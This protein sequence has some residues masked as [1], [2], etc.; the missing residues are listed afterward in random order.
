[1]NSALEPQ[2]D[3]QAAWQRASP[4]AARDWSAVAYFF[5]RDL[6]KRLNVPV[7]I[8][9]TTWSGT[10]AEAWTDAASLA[11]DPD[12]EPILR[13]WTDAPESE[14]ELARRPA[15]YSLEF[16]DFELFADDPARGRV[17]SDFDDGALK[18]STGGSWTAVRNPSSEFGFVAQGRGGSAHALRYSGALVASTYAALN[19]TYAADNSPVD[20]SRYAGVRF[21]VRGR[22][23]F[24]IHSLQPSITDWD[25]YT[26]RGFAATPEWQRVTVRFD[27]LRQA[28][29]G[30]RHEFTP[31]SLTGFSVEIL[32]QKDGGP[33]LP[34]SSLFNA[35]V[36][37]LT[38]YSIRGAIWYQGESNAGRSYQYRKLL[39]ALIR[40]WRSAWGE[41]DFPFLV[42]QLAAYG[43]GPN[44]A[45]Q[46]GWAELREAQLMTL[47]NT[48][49]TGLAVTIDVGEPGNVHPAR[50]AEVGERLALWALGTTYGRRLVYSGPL[51]ESSKVEGGRVRIRFN[52]AGG[53]LATSDGGPLKGF[54]VAGADRVFHAAQA[55]VEGDAVVVSSPEVAR[56]L[57][58][59]YA[60]ADSPVCNLVNREGLPAS[61][62][63]TDDWP[64][65]TA[66]SK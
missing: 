37:P 43:A 63:R 16:D 65:V 8:I 51:Y 52:H 6:Q 22:G 53:G 2:T 26:T 24:K 39:P 40:G 28:G 18:T 57:A 47:R 19:A 14:K 44:A 56:P 13:R 50:K 64:G 12:F 36:A 3:F 31:Q 45:A 66:N 27:E 33:A 48:P 35:M 60:W 34:P 54:I 20:L 30:V 32:R 11:A 9:Q 62:F 29:W 42:V 5:A 38:A 7:G 46:S 4:E 58:V 59:R 15:P 49:Q 10:A 23:F 1:M 17:L 21:N 41:G 55:V 61:P 25:D